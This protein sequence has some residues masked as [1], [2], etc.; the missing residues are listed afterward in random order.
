VFGSEFGLFIHLNNQS[1]LRVSMTVNRHHDPGK[2]SK[3]QHLIG[4][5]LQVQRFSPISSGWGHGSIQADTV[6]EELK[7]SQH[8]LKATRGSL[9]CRQLGWGYYSPY[10]QWHTYTNKATPTLTGPHLLIVPLPGLRIYKPP[11]WEFYILFWR[12]TGED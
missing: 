4:A 11:H 6:Q 1:C 3:R 5:G 12:Q 7:D 10:P 8:H 2:S 9:A